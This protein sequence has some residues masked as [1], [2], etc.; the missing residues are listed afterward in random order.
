MPSTVPRIIPVLLAAFVVLALPAWAGAQDS[1][2]DAY[3][4]NPPS[5]TGNNDSGDDGNAPGGTGSAG[6]GEDGA[7]DPGAAGSQGTASQTEAQAA[8]NGT[9]NGELPATG[10]ETLLLALAG[11]GLLASGVVLLRRLRHASSML[12]AGPGGT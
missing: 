4:E 12:P 1:G 6:A 8:A 5:A 7:S 10:L 2:L 9:P 11:V 3:Q